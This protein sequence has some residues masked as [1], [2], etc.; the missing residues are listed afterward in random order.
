[1]KKQLVIS[2]FYIVSACGAFLALPTHSA[3]ATT[4]RTNSLVHQG[5]TLARIGARHVVSSYWQLAKVSDIHNPNP[6]LPRQRLC[7]LTGPLSEGPVSTNQ[8]RGSADKSSAP[9]AIP[10]GYHAW[11]PVPDFPSDPYWQSHGQCTWWAAIRR[12]DENFLDL[13]TYAYQWAYNA[14]GRGFRTGYTPTVGATVVFQR[15]VLGAS[16]WGGHVGHVEAVY[17]NGSFLISEMNFYANGGGWDRVSYRV[18]PVVPGV[19]FIY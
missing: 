17:S 6:S 14:P 9:I 1:M 10:P 19:S 12:M 5:D 3:E 11:G 2:T 16:S 8:E 15:G 18:I 4:C 13:G 7:I